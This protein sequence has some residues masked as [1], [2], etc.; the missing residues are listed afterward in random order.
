MRRAHLPV[1]ICQGCFEPI[2][3]DEEMV[4]RYGK[5]YHYR[6]LELAPLVEEKAALKVTPRDVVIRY[7]RYVGRKTAGI[8]RED[9]IEAIREIMTW[10][11]DQ[12]R[13]GKVPTRKEID[14]KIEEVRARKRP[15][16]M[17]KELLELRRKLAKKHL[18]LIEKAAP[19]QGKPR[20]Q[21]ETPF[22][23]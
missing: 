5:V 21:R 13:A 20:A 23:T 2:L 18:E 4:E 1:Y 8:M 19:L 11:Y 14:R 3:G 15:A 10:I 16:V 6:C 9:R 17:P 12:I 22:E 7:F